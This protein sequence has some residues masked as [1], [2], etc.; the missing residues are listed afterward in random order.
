MDIKIDDF[1]DF[2]PKDYL[3]EY[4]SAVEKEN[5]F[6]LDFFHTTYYKFPKNGSLIEIGGGPTLYQLI[7]A[8]EVVKDITFTEFHPANLE[9]CKAWLEKGKSAFDW[10]PFLEYVKNLE[11]INDIDILEKRMR[12]KIIRLIPCDLFSENPIWKKEKFDIMSINF[13]AESIT[14]T[15]KDF[16]KVMKNSLSLL[17]DGG[18]LVMTS[19]EG[20]NY[21]RVGKRNF[22]AYPITESY[23]LNFFKKNNFSIINTSKISAENNRDYTG[24]IAV[25]AKLNTPLDQNKT[26][27]LDT[28][29]KH[30]NN[31][32][33]PFHVPGHKAGRGN[34][35]LTKTLGEK[36]LQI[37]LN[38]MSDIDD[39]SQPVSSIKEAQ[40]LAAS[41]FHSDQAYFLV[42]GTTSGIQTMILSQF[43]QGDKLLLP[44]NLH[45]SAFNALILSGVT[46]I[47]IPIHYDNEYK[48][49]GSPKKETI[50]KILEEQPD[51]KG[52]LLLNPSYYGVCGDLKAIVKMCH[53]KNKIVLV[54]EAHGTH[55]YFHEDLPISAMEAG[56]DMSVVSMHK[57]G[58]S[59]TQS[60]ILL[61]NKKRISELDVKRLLN[62][63]TSTS[64]SYLLMVSLDI[65][66]KQMAL[67][68]RE[69]IE[70]NIKTANYL[71][72]EI[73]NIPGL[74][75]YGKNICD[76]K[77]GINYLDET[78]I[79]IDV[80][81]WN[82]TGFQLER[83]LAN[84]YQIQIELSDMYYV[85][86]LITFADDEASINKLIY[87]LQALSKKH[88]N[89]ITREK[90]DFVEPGLP[91]VVLNPQKA[92]YAKRA[93]ISLKKTVGRIAAEE[94]MVYP[95]GIP[96]I[97]AGER[98]SKNVQKYLINLKSQ[99]VIFQGA[100]NPELDTVLIIEERKKNR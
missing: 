18:H 15:Q 98:I 55:F 39:L 41:L 40:N 3:K 33:T 19:L 93:P 72:K 46:P 53:K 79:F 70:K 56:A 65:A 48:I 8:S 4:Y 21:Y 42:N 30:I 49:S 50:E 20:A 52:I 36:T 32:F 27:V 80:R 12:E 75:S 5:A 88:F 26:P 60:S 13:C 59:L 10:S 87:S 34:L 95:P 44:R 86:V 11:G 64:A 73:N 81:E 45:K 91:E 2:S 78:K 6:L 35:E 9:A 58:G 77:K 61:V 63:L 82:I 67:L 22:P 37:D 54:D 7:S 57:T 89:T 28:I 74:K 76:A 100:D 31:K 69:L 66:R 68:G 62:I 38:S 14:N 16:E 71:R 83:L 17:K 23:L 29:M 99:N 43:R 51:I 94:I 97:L 25:L 24:I 96:I 85:F 47:Y 90:I 1:K 92:F 84:E